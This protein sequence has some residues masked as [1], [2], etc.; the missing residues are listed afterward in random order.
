MRLG[1][2]NLVSKQRT[3][4]VAGVD[5]HTATVVHSTVDCDDNLRLSWR[6]AGV[7]AANHRSL[8]DETAIG[9]HKLAIYSMPGDQSEP[10]F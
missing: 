2:I 7:L 8:A 3:R 10:E 1:V 4:I 5:T 9:E 6:T